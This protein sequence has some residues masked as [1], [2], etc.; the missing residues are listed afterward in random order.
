MDPTSWSSSSEVDTPHRGQR[1]LG[2]SPAGHGRRLATSPYS[3]RG[4]QRVV[5]CRPTRAEPQ[6]LPRSGTS[7][8]GSTDLD[9]YRT[10][11]GRR[12]ADDAQHQT[13][14]DERQDEREGPQELIQHEELPVM[15]PAADKL[16]CKSAATDISMSRVGD[17]IARRQGFAGTGRVRTTLEERP[18]LRR[19]TSREP[20]CLPANRLWV[21]ECL[22]C[23]I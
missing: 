6:H 4:V 11:A 5:H 23:T 7:Y 21:P 1:L 22:G 16:A 3:A 10:S 14:Q 13:G 18:A 20:W 9:G 8:R 19:T 17:A 2:M 12:K 15:D